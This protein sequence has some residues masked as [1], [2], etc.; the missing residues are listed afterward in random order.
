MNYHATT[1]SQAGTGQ[2]VALQPTPPPAV[3]NAVGV[4]YAGA[5]ASLIHA[6][7]ALVTAGATK[8]VLKHKHPLWSAG[9]LSTLTT[10]TVI[11]IA[12]LA[13]IGAVLFVWIA[14]GCRRGSNKARI[15]AAV[16]AALG[17][18]IAIYDVSIGRGT[19]TLIMGFVVTAIGL[20]SVVILCQR[21]SSA[22]FRQFTRPQ[23]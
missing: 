20:A 12:V 2:P 18:L 21:S 10:I 19:A 22:Y 4:M 14:R 5:A 9:T 23:F 8:T 3:R 1:A 7:V 11:A 13:L 16:L 6:V 17:V 15:T